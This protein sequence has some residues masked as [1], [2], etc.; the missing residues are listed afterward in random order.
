MLWCWEVGL[1]QV[2]YDSTM[3]WSLDLDGGAE[4]IDANIIHNTD[5]Q[6]LL[7]ALTGDDLG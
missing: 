3:E 1:Y 2:G 7:G 4:D 6:K 5:M